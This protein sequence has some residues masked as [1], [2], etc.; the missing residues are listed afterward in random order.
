[1]ATIFLSGVYGVGK[2]TLGYK[3]SDHTNIPFYSAGDLISKVNGEKFGKNKLVVDK[4]RNQEILTERILEIHKNTKTIILAGHFCIVNC[5][6]QADKLPDDVFN[7]L[8][9]Q[10]IILLEADSQTIL[11]HLSDRDGKSYSKNLIE[12]LLK[13]ERQAACDTANRLL[14]PL[15]IHKMNYSD[16]DETELI[17]EL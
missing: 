17:T 13:L 2:S 8:Q 11:D 6:G 15:V 5:Q 7:R 16:A 1:M 9:L 3:L 12:G 10:K 14:C 4:K